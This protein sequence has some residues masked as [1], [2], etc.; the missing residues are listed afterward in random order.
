MDLSLEESPYKAS[1]EIIRTL[2]P[3]TEE[4]LA[5]RRKIH[6]GPT[7]KK[8][9]LVFDL[10]QTLVTAAAVSDSCSTEH[11]MV[12][13]PHAFELIHHLS[14]D[15]ELVMFTAANAEY[16]AQA[17][18]FFNSPV[19]YFSKLLTNEFCMLT[20]EGYFV[21]DLRIFADRSLDKM[22]IVDD[23]IIS[24]A[25]QLE[26]GIPVEPFDGSSDDEELLYLKSYL[27]SIYSLEDAVKRNAELI[28][29]ASA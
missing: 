3:P 2:T 4:Q 16:A 15:Y 23:S 28:G 22:F 24:F 7:T 6:L 13:R 9:T 11:T 20:K 10:D 27:D 29:I 25:F 26:N 21:K 18:E 1:L 5:A 19:V 14:R 12:V 8:L 17:F